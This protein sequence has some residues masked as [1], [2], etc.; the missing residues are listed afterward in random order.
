ML[1]PPSA[2]LGR[3]EDTVMIHIH[4]VE[5]RRRPPRRALLGTLDVLLSGE[6]ARGRRC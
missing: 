5:L 1:V 2:H 6:P 3:F 4:P